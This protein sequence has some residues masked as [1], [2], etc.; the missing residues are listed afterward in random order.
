MDHAASGGVGDGVGAMVMSVDKSGP[1]AAAG[2]RQG[3]VIVSWNGEKLSSV[4]SLFRSLG[5][6]SVG[7]VAD[8]VVRRAGEPVNV[9]IMIGERPRA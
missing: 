5:P 8:I 2:L 1:S 7:K 4:R 6:D 9:K 3:D